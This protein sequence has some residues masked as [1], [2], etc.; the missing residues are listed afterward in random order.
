MPHAADLIWQAQDLMERQFAFLSGAEDIAVALGV[1]QCHLCRVFAREKCD[2]PGRMLAR[3]RLRNAAGL[4]QTREYSVE[5]VAQM[6]GFSC[7]NYFCKVFRRAYGVSPGQYAL[8][9]SD[10]P[11]LAGRVLVSAIP[12]HFV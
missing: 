7:G 3:I 10:A 1:T 6:C 5:L 12:Q 11:L 2:S 9:P 8:L 4:L